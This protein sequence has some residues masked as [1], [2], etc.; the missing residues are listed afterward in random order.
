MEVQNRGAKEAKIGGRVAALF[1]STREAIL[2]LLGNPPSETNLPAAFWPEFADQFRSSVKPILLE[3]ASDQLAEV[4]ASVPIGGDVVEIAGDVMLAVDEAA[5][6]VLGQVTNTSQTGLAREIRRFFEQGM[7]FE[8]LEQRLIPLFGPA[9]AESIAI[10]EVTNA[11][12][13]A[14]DIFF[15]SLG[16]AADDFIPTWHT[17]EDERVCPICMPMNGL[18]AVDGYFVHPESGQMYRR[19]PA[20]P[21]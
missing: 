21:R 17:S 14:E 10:T 15:E 12:A 1:A 5:E 16:A 7:T 13:I 6:T 3:I 11:A 19:P 2:A 8:E 9:R 4:A 20:H 18:E